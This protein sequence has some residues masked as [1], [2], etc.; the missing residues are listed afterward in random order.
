MAPTRRPLAERFWEKVLVRPSECWLWLGGKNPDGYG[1]IWDDGETIGAHRVAYRL[2]IGPI[3]PNMQVLHSCDN[4]GC[5]YFGHLSL[6]TTQ[7]NTADRDA[8]GRGARLRGETNPMSKLT[9]EIVRQIRQTH[10]SLTEIGDRFGLSF[11]HV[12]RLKRRDRWGHL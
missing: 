1:K 8:K 11:G 5:V 10:G 7:D 6:G 4:P 3:P 12:G 9:P 2:C